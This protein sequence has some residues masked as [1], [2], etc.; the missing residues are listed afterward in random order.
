ML[1]IMGYH[2]LTACDG[3]EALDIYTQQ[4]SHIDIVILDLTMPKM[5]GASCMQALHRIN[6][7]VCVILS[8]GYSMDM[9]SAQ[10][11]DCIPAAMLQKP[12][13]ADILEA[14]VQGLG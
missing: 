7:A 10:L 5:D 2:V 14:T 1:E 11:G 13:S 4:G 12:Y 6:P 9:I 8:S 3:L